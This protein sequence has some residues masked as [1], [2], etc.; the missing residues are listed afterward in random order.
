[1]CENEK[2]IK[3]LKQNDVRISTKGK[4]CL[5]DFVENIIK[6]KNPELYIKRVPNKI[7]IGD[8]CYIKPDDTSI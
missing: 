5:N 2:L 7:T 4:L 8:N 3:V 6:S 1:M